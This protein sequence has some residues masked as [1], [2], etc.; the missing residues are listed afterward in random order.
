MNVSIV[1]KLLAFLPALILLS[2]CSLFQNDKDR[3]AEAIKDYQAS[4]PYSTGEGMML[5]RVDYSKSANVIVFETEAEDV[6][7]L[8][9]REKDAIRKGVRD[10]MKHSFVGEKGSD[11]YNVFD[12]VRP[13]FRFLIRNA[14]SGRILY[15]E[16][17]LAHEYL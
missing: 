13:D 10:M 8:S 2:S 5:V 12:N 16:T 1:R 3:L 17:F 14:D 6:Y 7:S 15:D 11:M 4:L 9:D